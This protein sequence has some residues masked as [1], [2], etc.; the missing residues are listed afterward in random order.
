MK[1]AFV[2]PLRVYW[3]FLEIFS[4][5]RLVAIRFRELTRADHV[6]PCSWS[7]LGPVCGYQNYSYYYL[8]F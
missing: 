6:P 8:I 3:K 4:V 2:F 7:E 1:T 5:F